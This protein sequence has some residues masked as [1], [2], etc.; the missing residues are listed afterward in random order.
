MATRTPAPQDWVSALRASH[1]RLAG[2]VSGLDADVVTSQSYD[3]GWSIGQVLS[4][5][6]SGAVIFGLFL[7]VALDGADTP[8]QETLQPIWGEWNAKGP[9]AWRDEALAA[10]AAL[11][12]RIEALD[13]AAVESFTLPLF[14]SE[15][16]LS[17]F[18]RMRLSEHAFH[19]WDVAVSLDASA[20]LGA[21]AVALLIDGLE[22]MVSRAG[23]AHGEAF[24]VRVGTSDPHRDLIVAVGESVTLIAAEAEAEDSYDGAVDLTSEAFLRLVV[25]RLDPDHTTPHTEVGSRGLADLRSV[26]PGF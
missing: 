22:P 3:T 7:D 24:R 17:G 9:L 21:D 20:T 10:D 15:Y 6:G 8:G 11:V 14:G 26:F 12:E 19:T 16:D 5:L 1:E 23:K 25:G 13:A 18:V 2:L 4:H